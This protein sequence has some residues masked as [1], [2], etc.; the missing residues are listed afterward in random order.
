MAADVGQA[1]MARPS[2]SLRAVIIE[3]TI[4]QQA[5]GVTS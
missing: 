5:P 1:A 2:P 4:L 3:A